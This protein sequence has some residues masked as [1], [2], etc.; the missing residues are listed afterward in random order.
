MTTHRERIEACLSNQALDHPPV[1][2]WRHWPVDDQTPHEGQAYNDKLADI[3]YVMQIIATDGYSVTLDSKTVKRNND[4]MVAYVVNENPLPDKYYP[5]RLVGKSLQKNQMVGMIDMIKLVIDPKLVAQFTVP[6]VALTST[7]EPSQPAASPVALAPGDLL[8]TGAVD[9]DV[10]LK[11]SDLKAMNVVKIPAEH[12]K[13]GKMDFEGVLLSEL[14]TKVKVKPTA[15]KIV[16]TASDGYTTE[17]ALTDVNNCPKCMLAFTDQPG[18]YQLVMP[19]LP[20]NTWAKQ[21]VKIEF[22]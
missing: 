4:I 20:S 16:V 15:T 22:K 3:G 7:P 18:V 10:T 11:E 5:L 14:F 17:I 13:K 12:P 19:D 21:V 1:A 2:L 9:Q 6:T 8:L